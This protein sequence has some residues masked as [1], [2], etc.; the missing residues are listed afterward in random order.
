M[1]SQLVSKETVEDAPST[2]PADTIEAV[3]LTGETT[4][5]AGS[6]VGWCF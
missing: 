1:Q 2:L 4:D 3:L 5:S 6:E